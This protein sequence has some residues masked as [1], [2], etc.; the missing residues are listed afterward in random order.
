M[1]PKN[2]SEP[3]EA[4]IIGNY[5]PDHL[6]THEWANGAGKYLNVV[7]DEESGTP[8]AIDIE[9]EP[10]ARNRIKVT[11]TFVRESNDIR[12]VEIKKFKH[13]KR[14]G[15]QPAPDEEGGVGHQRV[16]LRPFSFEKLLA[17]LRFITE[18]DVPGLLGAA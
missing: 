13:Y 5:R 10:H 7:I 3:T 17:F 12:M 6:Y 16:T 1:T 9:L 14:Q 2:A 8:K 4:E 11:I 18:L 15:W